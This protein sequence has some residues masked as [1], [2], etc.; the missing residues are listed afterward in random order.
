MKISLIL[1]SIIF[2]FAFGCVPPTEPSTRYKGQIINLA[3]INNPGLIKIVVEETINDYYNYFV[4]YKYTNNNSGLFSIVDFTIR[5]ENGIAIVDKITKVYTPS[6]CL[7]TLNDV[8]TKY[9]IREQNGSFQHSNKNN[10]IQGHIIDL[11]DGAVPLNSSNQANNLS[12]NI[13]YNCREFKLVELNDV[14]DGIDTVWIPKSINYDSSRYYI[15]FEHLNNSH[16]KVL[17]RRIIWKISE[18]HE[19]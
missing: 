19:H 7:D 17:G 2:I 8:D 6:A 13:T 18:K 11:D 10:H 16:T 4:P 15:I 12:K 14:V 3:N 1:L 9:M 5:H